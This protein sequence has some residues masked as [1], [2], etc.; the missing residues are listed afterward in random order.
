MSTY[1]ERPPPPALAAYVSCVWEQRVGATS[2]VYEQPVFPDGCIDLV[3]VDGDAFVAGPATG[4]VVASM[5]PHS[6]TVGVRL[7]RGAAP[8][9]LGLSAHG[10]V[11]LNVSFGD[12]WGR[13]GAV[14]ADRIADALPQHR[15]DRLTELVVGRLEQG[16][17]LD[18]QVAA[19]SALLESQPAR[20]LDDLRDATG[21]SSRQL[22]R[23]VVDTVGYSPRLLA[24]V[25]RFQRFLRSARATV[26]DRDLSR[27]A[28]ESGYADQSHLTRECRR[29]TGRTPAVLFAEE[30]RR[31]GAP[32]VD[33]WPER[34][35]P[36][37]VA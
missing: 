27:L 2:D 11:D 7:R 34:S 8:A 16:G 14:I 20:S 13:S 31:L 26:G 1:R 15:L 17:E 33:A 12:V 18:R 21:L 6:I 19:V 10:L 22:R 5:S 37:A 23:R 3:A 30:A 4:P 36:D 32:D 25:L 28:V 35:R 24:G 29:F 9:I